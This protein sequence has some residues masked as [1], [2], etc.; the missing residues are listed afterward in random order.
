VRGSVAVLFPVNVQHS[1]L[2]IDLV[3]S[4]AN[5]FA[6]SQAVVVGEKD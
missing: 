1:A 6:N 4:K 5:E 3:P 2:Q